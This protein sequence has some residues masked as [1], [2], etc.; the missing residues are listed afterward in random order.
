MIPADLA[1]RLRLIN[2]ASF[3]NTEPPVAGLQRAREIEAQRAK[4][5][6]GAAP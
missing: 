1:T 5:A 4:E 3:F 2:E 6:E